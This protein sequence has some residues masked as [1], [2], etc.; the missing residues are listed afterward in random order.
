MKIKD[1]YLSPLLL[2]VRGIK[3][4]NMFMSMFNF[5]HNN[6]IRLVKYNKKLNCTIYFSIITTLLFMTS[7]DNS[8]YSPN[9]KGVVVSIEKVQDVY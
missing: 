3:Q 6:L 4:N 8:F 9:D 5:L 2:L 7:C 1:S